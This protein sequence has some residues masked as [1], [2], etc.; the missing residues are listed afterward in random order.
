[1]QQSPDKNDVTQKIYDD[2]K[3]E[4]VKRLGPVKQQK[5]NWGNREGLEYLLRAIWETN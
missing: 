3:K 2:E 5:S 1:M 4:H